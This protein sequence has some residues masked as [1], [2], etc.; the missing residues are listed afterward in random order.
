MILTTRLFFITIKTQFS[1]TCT[2]TLDI[3][4][5]YINFRIIAKVWLNLQIIIQ[6][7]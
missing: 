4:Y 7:I 3:S 1:I 2:D 5:M 6:E